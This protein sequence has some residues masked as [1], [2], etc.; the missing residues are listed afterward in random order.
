MK[1]PEFIIKASADA[2]QGLLTN[3]TLRVKLETDATRERFAYPAYVAR[4]SVLHAEALWAELI[5]KQY[6]REP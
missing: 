1:K 5:A 2:M 6:A 4:T 3:E